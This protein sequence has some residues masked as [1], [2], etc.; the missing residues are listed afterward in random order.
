MNEEVKLTFGSFIKNKRIE[1]DLTLREFC[2]QYG[3]DAGNI[4]RMENDILPAPTK[5]SSLE[6]IAKALKLEENSVEW[7]QFFDLASLSRKEI[8][9]DI[10]NSFEGNIHLLPALLRATKN[11]SITKT[12]IL[13]LIKKLRTETNE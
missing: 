9:E 8:P 7:V 4:S 13:D 2:N 11:K 12:E 6:G 10:V 5:R 1:Q 3:L